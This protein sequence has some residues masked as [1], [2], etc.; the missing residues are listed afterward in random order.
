MLLHFSSLLKCP[1]L[2]DSIFVCE[3]IWQSL[4]F[5]LFLKVKTSTYAVDQIGV[6]E[7]LCLHKKYTTISVAKNKHYIKLPEILLDKTLRKWCLRLQT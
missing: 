1:I 2:E 6:K 3:S 7:E 5:F 4:H